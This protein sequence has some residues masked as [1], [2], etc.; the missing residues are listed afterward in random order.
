MDGRV[1]STP[2]TLLDSVFP[3][4]F[5]HLVDFG[6]HLRKFALDEA[7]HGNSFIG[8]SSTLKNVSLSSSFV[9]VVVAVVFIVTIVSILIYSP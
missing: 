4:R 5:R 6:V 7:G 2:F 8:R 1:T 9:V 3:L